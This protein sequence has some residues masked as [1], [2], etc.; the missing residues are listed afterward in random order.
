VKSFVMVLFLVILGTGL[1][2]AKK[3]PPNC[4]HRKADACE[5]VKPAETGGS[6]LLAELIQGFEI[7]GGFRWDFTEECASCAAPYVPTSHV[8]HDP[9]FIGAQLRVPVAQYG[10]LFVSGDRDFSEAPHGNVR[11]GVY[12]A[13]WRKP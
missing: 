4:K 9:A 10:G 13:P 12:F 8:S 7:T 11:V 5:K 1:A 6:V 2:E 3:C